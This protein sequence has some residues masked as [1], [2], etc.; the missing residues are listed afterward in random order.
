MELNLQ[1]IL[2]AHKS[3]NTGVVGG[4]VHDFLRDMKVEHQ[5]GRWSVYYVCHYYNGQ[6]VVVGGNY[7]FNKKPEIRIGEELDFLTGKIDS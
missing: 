2:A 6:R 4:V 3:Y 5:E 1:T 7:V